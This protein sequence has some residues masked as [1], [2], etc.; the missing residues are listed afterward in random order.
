MATSLMENIPLECYFENV[1]KGPFDE[2]SP[3][4]GIPLNVDL[5]LQMVCSP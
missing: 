1:Q 5:V 4:V 2:D 3:V